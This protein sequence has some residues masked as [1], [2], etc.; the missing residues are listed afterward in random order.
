M[1]INRCIPFSFKMHPYPPEMPKCCKPPYSHHYS[2]P[3]TCHWLFQWST[4][5]AHWY[6]YGSHGGT[7]RWHLWT[8]CWSENFI[9]KQKRT[10]IAKFSYV[11][12]SFHVF[13][14][15]L[16]EPVAN[17]W[18]TICFDTLQTFKNLYFMR[19]KDTTVSTV[20]SLSNRISLPTSPS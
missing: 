7:F 16:T 5:P 10:D 6:E 20:F 9:D 19:L 4:A 17:R 8:G 1:A 12:S 11:Q 14:Y 3:Y 2:F 15:F 13:R 18:Q